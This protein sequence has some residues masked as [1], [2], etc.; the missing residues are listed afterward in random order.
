MTHVVIIGA[1]GSAGAAVAGDLVE[2]DDI[3]LTLIDNGEPGG[4]LC[5]LRGCMP[6]KEVLSAGAH[7]FQARHDERLVGDVP[8]VDLEA[9]VERKDDHVLTGPGTAET[10]STRW[11][12][13]TT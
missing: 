8:E 11:P 13:A 6:S 5:I 7:R 1:Y 9:V 2:A 10:P 12:N 3:E 4:G